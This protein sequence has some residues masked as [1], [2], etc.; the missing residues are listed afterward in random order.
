MMMGFFKEICH[1]IAMTQPEEDGQSIIAD[2]YRNMPKM[3]CGK[4]LS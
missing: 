2:I 3:A 1:L 4:E